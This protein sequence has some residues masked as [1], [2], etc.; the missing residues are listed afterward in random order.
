MGNKGPSHYFL[1][2]KYWKTV[3][4]LLEGHEEQ[5]QN[6]PKCWT[7]AARQHRCYITV[8][9]ALGFV[10]FQQ[11]WETWHTFLLGF[12]QPTCS[13]SVYPHVVGQAF[14]VR[15]QT[16]Q[17]LDIKVMEIRHGS[18][19]DTLASHGS[20]GV[21]HR[22][23]GLLFIW[24]LFVSKIPHVCTTATHNTLTSKLSDVIETPHPLVLTQRLTL[25]M[26][27][28]KSSFNV[29]PDFIFICENNYNQQVSPKCITCCRDEEG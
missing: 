27:S 28:F 14:L 9:P 11:L 13:A 4:H 22:N 1:L 21:V 29:Y 16:G 17:A 10:L 15:L 6:I 2:P 3:G 23:K 7:T 18:I 25:S 20:L 24:R 19:P 5:E 8:P 12:L 26:H